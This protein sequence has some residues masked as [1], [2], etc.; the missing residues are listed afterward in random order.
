MIYLLP[1]LNALFG[2]MV[3]TLLFQMLFH[4]YRKRNF[5]IIDVQGF[6]PNKLPG[7]AAELGVYVSENFLN[8]AQLKEDL[9]SPDKL[10]QINALLEEKVDDFLRNKLK[11]KIPVFGMFITEGLITKM[12]ETLMAELENMIPDLIQYFAGD[13]EKKYDIKKITAEKVHGL[14]MRDVE[15]AF[16]QHAGKGINQLKA[17]CAAMGFVLGWLEIA[18]L[19]F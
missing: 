11:E 13:L 5:F 14:Q 12:K 4:P 15:R 7:L 2:W 9:L 18:L 10:K 16:Y 19:S 17:T 1:V 6:L 8:I 3:I